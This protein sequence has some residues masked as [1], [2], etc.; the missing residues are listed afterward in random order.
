LYVIFDKLD[1]VTSASY[2]GWFGLVYGV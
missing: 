2:D 1:E